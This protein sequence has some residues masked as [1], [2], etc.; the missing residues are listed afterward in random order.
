M[1]AQM[2]K[3]RNKVTICAVV[4]FLNKKDVIYVKGTRASGRSKYKIQTPA[5]LT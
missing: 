2:K 4:S 1:T 3:F 5:K